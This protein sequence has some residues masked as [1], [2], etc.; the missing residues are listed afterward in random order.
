MVFM[1]I[2]STLID[3]LLNYTYDYIIEYIL[4]VIILYVIFIMLCIISNCLY[5]RYEYKFVYVYHTS[6][7]P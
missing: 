3:S 5:C 7:N 6:N 1:Y 2:V 4:Y